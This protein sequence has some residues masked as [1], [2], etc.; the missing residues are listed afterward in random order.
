MAGISS[1]AAMGSDYPE[2]KKKY[3]GIE[4][5]NDLE[6]QTYD[7]FFRE[8]DPQT[9]RWWQVDPKTEN[10]EMWSPYASNYDNPLRYSDPLGD[11]G[12]ECCWELMKAVINLITPEQQATAN[13][14]VEGVTSTVQQMGTNAKA[15]WEAGVD[16]LHQT[17][18]NPLSL[19]LGSA[20]ME[21]NA[22]KGALGM[23]AKSVNL[24][25]EG[26]KSSKLLAA[27]KK[28][29]DAAK[30]SQGEGVFFVSERGT[31]AS[32]SQARMKKSFDNANLNSQPTTK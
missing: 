23:E 26:I 3:N 30:G 27:E 8:L 12:Q 4:L 7:A 19:I 10:M 14:V 13:A 20:G 6:I 24:L 1:K 32:N 25:S 21:M 9:G 18:A 22:A 31:A 16:P 17:A 5:E 11:E 2:N 15:R 28:L 29:A